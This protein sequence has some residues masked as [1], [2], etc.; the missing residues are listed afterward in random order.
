MAEPRP[1]V[2][3]V[4]DQPDGLGPVVEA[5]ERSGATALVANDGQAALAL[6]AEVTPDLVLMDA[7]MPGL[8]GFETCR[9]LKRLPGLAGVP[10]VFMTGLTE[11]EHVV[12]GLRAGGVD[13]VTKPLV[14]DELLAR[15]GA[16]LATARV[17][18][19]AH[20]A[21]DSAGSY[22]LALD[23]GGRVLWCTPQA[24]RLIEALRPPGS[25]PDGSLPPGPWLGRLLAGE[26]PMLVEAEGGTVRL[27]PLGRTGPDEHLV[28]LEAVRP[29][30]VEAA[31]AALRQAYPLT[32]REA[33]VLVWIA[34]G[35]SNRDIG[36]ILGL[37]PRTVNK[38]LEGIYTK[39]G[40]ENRA[41]AAVLA[42][43]AI[44]G[45]S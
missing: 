43:Q 35:K 11:T 3:V 27:T 17:A 22:L 10:V 31:G 34:R 40:V 42:T 18:R 15:I 32:A 45:Q 20:A 23:G 6:V 25:P 21:L 19:S 9:R 26:A 24:Q 14:L 7:V 16:H 44:A 2:L 30:T 38:H 8:D 4:D 36:T 13:Y 28:R 12:E 33:E 39:L 29:E 41:S 1:I 5:L 37:S